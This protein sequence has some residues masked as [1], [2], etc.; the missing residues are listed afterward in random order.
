VSH[1]P[2]SPTVPFAAITPITVQL[3]RPGRNNLPDGVRITEQ[4]LCDS[5]AKHG[6]LLFAVSRPFH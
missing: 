2:L 5:G 1:N 4:F 3:G 6:Y